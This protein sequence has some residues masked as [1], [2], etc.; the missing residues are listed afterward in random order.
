MKR[1]LLILILIFFAPNLPFAEVF[2]WVDEKGGVHF[3]DDLMQIPP[4]HRPKTEKMEIPEAGADV[5]DVKKDGGSA[6][7]AK[8]SSQA[9]RSGKG[10]E[11]WRGRVEEWKRKLNALRDRVEALRMKY[12]DLTEKIND[13]K[14]S[15]IRANI[16]KERDLIKNEM[17]QI[18]TQVEEA[19]TVLEKKIPEEAELSGAKPEWVR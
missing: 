10:E 17:D 5:K 13:S 2:K 11:Y 8:G 15:V 16:R 12:N 14:N 7:K 1:I 19:K 18:R 3:T 9:D 4:K 6:P